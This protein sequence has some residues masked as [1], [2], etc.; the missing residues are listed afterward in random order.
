MFNRSAWRLQA[1]PPESLKARPPG[2]HDTKSHRQ[3]DTCM[4]ACAAQCTGPGLDNGKQ[5]EEWA[6]TIATRTQAVS[7]HYHQHRSRHSSSSLERIRAFHFLLCVCARARPHASQSPSTF[8]PP[9]PPESQ[10]TPDGGTQNLRNPW[11]RGAGRVC[12]PP[13]GG[14]VNATWPRGQ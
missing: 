5:K 1:R 7:T 13:S 12:H 11:K 3:H 9:H 2:I 14:P 6:K 8:D 10:R 4:A